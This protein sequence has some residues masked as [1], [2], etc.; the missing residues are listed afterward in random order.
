MLHVSCLDFDEEHIMSVAREKTVSRIDCTLYSGLILKCE[1]KVKA[2]HGVFVSMHR[3]MGRR[4]NVCA[5]E[6]F[7]PRDIGAGHGAI[8][9][10]VRH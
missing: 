8:H 6:I 1:I 5:T 10:I 4:H 9:G 2:R 3:K 7:R